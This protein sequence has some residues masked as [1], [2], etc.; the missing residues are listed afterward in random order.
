MNLAS[1]LGSVE[2]RTLFAGTEIPALTTKVTIA[3]GQN[4]KIGAILG[5]VTR[6]AASVAAKTG[7]NTGNG[8]LTMDATTPLLA[9][10]KS[11]IY[12][13]KCLGVVPTATGVPT[14]AAKT[15]GNT[16]NGTLTMD[17]TTPLLDNAQSGVYRAVC[18]AIKVTDPATPSRWRIYDPVG[19]VLEASLDAGGTF[20]SQIKFVIAD[21]AQ[22]FALNDQFNI[23]VASEDI[24]LFRVS[25][26]DGFVIGELHP[27]EIFANQIKFALADGETDFVEGDEFIFTIAAGSGEYKLVNITAVDGSEVADKILSEDVDATLAAVNAVAYKTGM[28]NYASLYVATGDT[29]AN[30]EAELSARNIHYKTEI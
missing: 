5:K 21:G 29:V 24:E 9:N 11:G 18:I 8:T 4:L 1:D 15:G 25:D 14:V 26:P 17:A 13:V 27:G 23:T 2:N 16:G 30:H 7:G 20:A 22:D 28:F 12:S 19:N 3:A 6:G 10:A